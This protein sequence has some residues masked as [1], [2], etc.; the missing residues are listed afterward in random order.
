M[1]GRASATARRYARA[2]LEVARKQ[3]DPARV[4]E[5]LC[6]AAALLEENRSLRDAL[7]HPGLRTERKSA[8][9]AAVFERAGA[10]ELLRRL[11]RLLGE[12]DRFD[13]LPAIASA[14]TEEWNLARGVVSA[15]VVSARPLE[16]TQRAALAEAI[17]RAT[18]QE[19][20]LAARVDPEVLGGLRLTMQGRTYDG[21]VR[22]RLRALRSRLVEGTGA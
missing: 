22:G 11:V 20:D 6:S 5:E 2:L 14:Y 12:R 10:T 3:A 1:S 9:A 18:G 8:L 16:R 4:H 13:L 7:T 17:R 21:T 15:E 19:A